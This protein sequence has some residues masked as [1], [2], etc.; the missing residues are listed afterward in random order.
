MSHSL[1]VLQNMESFKEF[2]SPQLDITFFAV[3]ESSRG[4]DC[5]L[6]RYHNASE[7]YKT[8]LIDGGYRAD[9]QKLAPLMPRQIDHVVCSHFDHDHIG[10][11][12]YLLSDQKIEFGRL[13][14]NREERIVQNQELLSEKNRRYIVEASEA[15]PRLHMILES[16]DDGIKLL[17]KA[18][19]RGIKVS[20]IQTYYY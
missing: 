9:A 17:A 12:I 4:G 16:L 11:L 7:R 6:L 19:E 18:R 10:G 1:E 15:N 14:I 13:W 2:I 3:G 5:I 8:I 20:I